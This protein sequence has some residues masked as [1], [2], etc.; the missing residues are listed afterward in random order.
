MK[1][2]LFALTA[3]A[4]AATA[5][6]VPASAGTIGCDPG[7]PT[8]QTSATSCRF[9][10]N[11]DQTSAQQSYAMAQQSYAMDRKVYDSAPLNSDLPFG[12]TGVSGGAAN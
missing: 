9:W 7:N 5:V 10:N 1:N 11:A 6:S 12:H 4:I 3:A 8:G 2:I